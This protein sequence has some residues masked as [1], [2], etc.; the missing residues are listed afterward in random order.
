M[1]NDVAHGDGNLGGNLDGGGAYAFL[2]REEAEPG[3]LSP[4][5]CT[6]VGVEALPVV[7]AVGGW[8]GGAVGPCVV[9]EHRLKITLADLVD[10]VVVGS[11]KLVWA[12]LEDPGATKLGLTRVSEE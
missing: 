8:F 6:P 1:S 10:L 9:A 7:G 5:D 4:R 2:V 11:R 12:W 3:V